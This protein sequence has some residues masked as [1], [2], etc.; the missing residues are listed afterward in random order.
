M[1]RASITLEEKTPNWVGKNPTGKVAM[2]IGLASSAWW[3]APT[4]RQI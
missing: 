4:Y 2:E 1:K 3:A